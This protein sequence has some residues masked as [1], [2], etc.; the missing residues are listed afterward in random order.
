M[1]VLANEGL[2]S[3]GRIEMREGELAP[4]RGT[5]VCVKGG[6]TDIH[7]VSHIYQHAVTG[8]EVRPY[9]AVANIE[10][11][12]L[13]L[14]RQ[15]RVPLRRCLRPHPSA[16]ELRPSHVERGSEPGIWWVFIQN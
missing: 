2:L 15:T 13:V 7:S 9:T 10:G 11:R 4:N 1:S 5:H 14:H 16:L 3:T 12:S 8:I 6:K